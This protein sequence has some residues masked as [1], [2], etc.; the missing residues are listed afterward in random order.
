MK[1][2]LSMT[3]ATLVLAG[4][5]RADVL[6]ESS[7][8]A[9][10]AAGVRAVVVENARGEIRVTA[11]ADGQIHLT[12][13]KEV[14]AGSSEQRRRLADEI[15][16][17]AGIEGG[18]Y[19]VR[20]NYGG[21]GSFHLSFWD[22][23]NGVDL[24]R[25]D[26]KL[27]LAV[28]PNLPL[29][30]HSSSGDLA[31]TGIVAPQSLESASGDMEIRNAGGE[32][33]VSTL[34]GDV[35]ATGLQRARLRTGSGDCEIED[36]SGP[37]TVRTGSGDITVRG[38][39]D[40]LDLNSVSGDLEVERAPRGVRAHTAS[41]SISVHVASGAIELDSSS[42]DLELALRDP[43]A[44]AELGSESGDVQVSLESV[45]GVAVRLET[46]SG[47]IDASAPMRVKSADRHMLVATIGTGRVPLTV[48]TS[49]GDIHVT[50]GDR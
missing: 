35:Q 10:S 39:R 2:W 27:S 13:L 12:A 21:S 30:L 40:S 42:G 37:V 7:S 17:S 44:R 18:S 43:L 29:A 36:V 47:S 19:T 46:S 23:V 6:R 49:S 1:A 34:S 9:T 8:Q 26:L 5:S 50:S 14:R 22:L 11:S 38:A 20:V 41:G 16:V 48:R 3:L 45:A 28:P 25:S 32:V 31:T 33:Q 24:P 4:P 15:T